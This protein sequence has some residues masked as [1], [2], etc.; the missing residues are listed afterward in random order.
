MSQL[1]APL[2]PPLPAPTDLAWKA[3]PDGTSYATWKGSEGAEQYHVTLKRNGAWYGTMTVNASQNPDVAGTIYDSPEVAQFFSNIMSNGGGATYTFEVVGLKGQSPDEVYSE[4][5][6]SEPLDYKLITTVDM[7]NVWTKLDPVN[8]VPFTAEIHPGEYDEDGVLFTDKLEIAA[9]YWTNTAQ[10]TD[11]ISSYKPKKP[12]VNTSYRYSVTIHAINGWAFKNPET[13][14]KNAWNPTFDLIVGG[15]EKTF[16]KW[17]TVAYGYDFKSVSF[18]PFDMDTGGGVVTVKPV[19]ISK[20]TVTGVADKTY[21]GKAISQTPTVKLKVNGTNVTL[22]NGTDYTLSYKNNVNMGTATVTITGKDNYKGSVSKTFKIT[23]KVTWKRLAGS[24]AF[25][26]MEQITKEYGKANVAI[27]TTNALAAK[28]VD[29]GYKDALAGA[30]LAGGFAA[31]MLTTSKGGLADKTKSELKRMGV[32]T[33]YII[34]STNE[35]ATKV[36]T[37]I[38]AMG[39]TV[40]RINAKTA[41]ERAVAAA[42]QVKGRSDTVIIATQ[43]NFKDALAIS[44]YAYASKSPILY[45]ETNKKLSSATVNYIKSGKFKKA[46]IVGGPVPLPASIEGQLK[47]AGIAAGSITRLAGSNQY[48]TAR[49]VAEWATGQLKNGTGGGTG[50]YQYAS[51]KFQPSV[52]LSANKLGVARADDN[53]IGWKDALAGAALCGKNKSVMLLAD[54]NNDAQA[55]AFVKANKA[56]ISMGYIFGGK[57]AV[58]AA[59]ETKLEKASM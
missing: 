42:K 27:V 31:P 46:I 23:K 6:T 26:T 43:N 33:V 3:N 48:K 1:P 39:I 15:G 41:S 22:K 17:S 50:L 37:Q 59:T 58:P 51:I 53:N 16:D 38:K 2:L 10:Y 44:S 7:G 12:K 9:E 28:G 45:A 52:K 34:G 29:A 21:T 19:D 47:S 32:K 54:K 14:G 56:Q 40:K 49:V 25:D 24:T 8:V 13:I 55:E 4:V 5:A 36:D 30:A 20:A 35:V 11:D 18:G 57:S